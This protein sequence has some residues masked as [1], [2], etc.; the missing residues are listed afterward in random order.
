M[1]KTIFY[2]VILL[3][4]MF[5][6]RDVQAQDGRISG[7][8][9]LDNNADGVFDATESGMMGMLITLSDVAGSQT[10]TVSDASGFYSFNDLNN[11]TYSVFVTQWVVGI[12]PST[13]ASQD[14]TISDANQEVNVDFGFMVSGGADCAVNIDDNDV[15]DALCNLDNGAITVSVE[16]G[17]A[18]YQI[19]V[20][21]QEQA[22]NSESI[23]LTD[24]APGSYQFV[25]IDAQQCE[26]SITNSLTQVGEPQITVQTE[27]AVCGSSNGSATIVIADDTGSG[28]FTL[29]S[30]NGVVNGED[31]LDIAG[32]EAGTYEA[33]LTDAQCGDF[34]VSFT[35]ECDQ[36]TG[37]SNAPCTDTFF[38]CTPPLASVEYCFPIDCDPDG[39]NISIN[40]HTGSLFGCSIQIDTDLCF[41]YTPLPA[42]LGQ[43]FLEV[44]VCD[45]SPDQLCSSSQFFFTVGP[46]CG[47]M[48]EDDEFNILA[49]APSD[50][51]VLDNDEHPLG[52]DFSITEA[53]NGFN[54]TVQLDPT[55]MFLIYTPDNGFAG[56]DSFN[57]TICD[58]ENNCVNVLVIVNVDGE[59]VENPCEADAGTVSPPAM[60]CIGPDQSVGSPTVSGENDSNGFVYIYVLTTDLDPT[61]NIIYDIVSLNTTGSF[62]FATIDN[63]VGTYNIHGLNFQGNVLDL[64]DFNPSTGEEVLNAIAA[65]TIC[66]DLIIPGYQLLVSDDCSGDDGVC[67]EVQEFCGEPAVPQDICFEFCDIVGTGAVIDSLVST[68]TNCSVH[69]LNDTCVTYAAVPGFFGLDSV[70]AYA[71]SPTG[72]DTAWAFINV[73]C[74][75][76][77]A[78]DDEAETD[79]GL[80]IFVNVLA[81]DSEPCNDDN[82]GLTI[83]LIEV[84]ENGTATNTGFGF[85]YESDA[86]FEGVDVFTYEVCNDCAEILCATATVTIAVGDAVI[87]P[88]PTTV[89]VQP[90]IV[91]TPQNT[92]L[93]VDVL[94]NDDDALTVASVG[95]AQ[96][97]LV[98]LD[99]GTITY[100]PNGGYIG[101]DF[102]DYTAC[103]DDG[104]CETTFVQVTVFDESENQAPV[105]SND[106]IEVA[107]GTTTEIPV[108][109]NDSDLENNDFSITDLTNNS[110]C[111]DAS[112][113]DDGSAIVFV[114]DADC[115][116]NVVVN[117]TIC[118]N[119]QADNCDTAELLIAVG[120]MLENSAPV[121]LNDTVFIND[122]DGQLVNVSEND[123]DAQG[124][125]LIYTVG[126]GPECAEG[127]EMNEDG[128]TIYDATD[129]DD[130]PE[131]LV[132]YVVCDD[133]IVSLCD[134]AFIYFVLDSTLIDMQDS[135]AIIASDDQASVAI[136]GS[137]DADVFENDQAP[138]N[139]AITITG[140]PENGTAA[141]FNNGT[142]GVLINYLPDLD[143]EGTDMVEYEL[144]FD[145][146]C[147]TA[148]LTIT[149]DVACSF[150]I[151]NGISPN[152]DG[153]MDEFSILGLEDCFPGNRELIIFNRWGSE[154]YRK[155]DFGDND[156]WDG[157]FENEPVPD[158]TYFYI[159]VA[160]GSD[161]LES[162][163]VAGYLEVYR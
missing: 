27:N 18:P 4:A 73:G 85:D 92:P 7:T 119:G 115:E 90:D 137:V 95:D 40:G 98:L 31:G 146:V 159:L 45:D 108:L 120:T 109:E 89:E 151:P 76:P 9:F 162:I 64:V 116:E 144:C 83:T 148:V 158:G 74:Q 103:D 35:I 19:L 131:D 134:T 50:L 2:A 57:Y 62:D 61:D 56:S 39:D 44:E 52:L 60:L 113:N 17:I 104:N 96:N 58:T 34:P 152:N 13:P 126:S 121:A 46:D 69:S 157:T 25:F 130:C 161:E 143:F 41:T 42:F 111:G 43:D 117:Y 68:F 156:A 47:P 38:F 37:G 149:V 123:S 48:G 112:I 72:L 5:I 1:K 91:S 128:L 11:S 66:A 99:N 110:D 81:N 63:G 10:T 53:T 129:I 28:D 97:G 6:D 101:D 70:I 36:N 55:G 3:L 77:V 82:S 100:T 12:E 145:G 153:I 163:D 132:L 133:A 59:I 150:D 75:S 94:S 86:G 22:E 88:D 154:V 33:T 51:M 118:E 106:V 138:D 8:V 14:V 78:L 16:G 155:Q 160:E 124:D 30:E 127:F 147:D 142:D 139:F 24:L 141:V 114:A 26:V 87:P 80:P 54:G 21:G 93:D 84:P 136:N 15:T 102:F 125:N 122:F 23:T 135:D 67:E 105:A 107:G 79:A 49:D 140:E 65:E 32:L 20:N 71:S 29:F